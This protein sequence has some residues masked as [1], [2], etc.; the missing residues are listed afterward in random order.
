[1]INYENEVAVKCGINA[2]VIADYLWNLK[3]S[4]RFGKGKSAYRYG[5]VWVRCSQPMIT[6]EIRYLTIDMVKGAIK[7]LLKENILRKE[8]FNDDKFDHTNWY[9]FTEYG[10]NL[11]RKGRYV[12]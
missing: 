3:E 12:L 2:A 8:C 4:H 7:N 11:V 1:M 9:T 10:E 5:K 6:S